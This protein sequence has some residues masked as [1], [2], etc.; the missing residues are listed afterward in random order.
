[1]QPAAS[2]GNAHENTDSVPRKQRAL[3]LQGGGALGAYEAGVFR[4]LSEKLSPLDNNKR[5]D[6]GQLGNLF[7]IVAGASAGAINAALIV[8]YVVRNRK[9]K[10]A[11]EMLC[12]FWQDVSTPTFWR[13]NKWLS[14]GWQFWEN[15]RKV[16]VDFFSRF[17]LPNLPSNSLREEWPFL[18]SYFLWPDNFGPLA[19][20]EA[21]RR[22]WSWYQFAFTPGGTPHVLSPG[23]VQPDFRFLNPFNSLVRYGNAPLVAAIKKYWDYEKHPIKTSYDR[24]E[25]RLLFVSVDVKDAITATFDSYEKEN[26]VWKT[27]YAHETAGYGDRKDRHVI[28]YEEGLKI[29]HLLTSMSSHLR[30]RPPALEA[31]TITEERNRGNNS[32]QEP[33]YFWDGFYLSNT[34]L[35]EVLQAH[36]DYW[37][38]VRNQR[39][40]VAANAASAMSKA[41]RTKADAVTVP[42]L[43]VYI[44][45]LYPTVEKEDFPKDPDGIQNRV[46]D[47]M[48]HDKTKYDEKV[49]YLVTDYIDLANRLIDMAI[50]QARDRNA[51]ETEIRN[52]L[53]T[54][55]AKSKKRDGKE[56]KYGDLLG[57]RFEVEKMVRIEIAADEKNDIYGKAFDFSS[58]TIAQLMEKGHSDALR[59]V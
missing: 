53:E 22:Y 15:A 56:R 37:H 43:E 47:I 39:G 41:T 30:Y 35:R 2:R 44:V 48:Y 29:D 49:A 40:A 57:G 14:S 5:G 12:N 58:D 42:D 3:I 46:G 54:I 6:G 18:S 28:E 7:D 11:S 27:E 23:I 1:M 25:P 13:G 50:K 33:R 24:N 21:V 9:W 8:D 4:A 55:D 16:Q 51:A 45:D 20:E 31:T 36:R 34:P 26:G 10:G 17:V 59:Y 32:K 38:K 52:L 19:S